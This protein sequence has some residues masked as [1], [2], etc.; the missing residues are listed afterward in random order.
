MANS[1]KEAFL[2]DF[3]NRYGDVHKLESSLSLYDIGKGA[4]RVYISNAVDLRKN[5]GYNHA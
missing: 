5:P 2:K 1:T 4:G 3:K